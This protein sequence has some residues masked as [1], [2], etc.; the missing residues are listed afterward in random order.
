VIRRIGRGDWTPRATH[1]ILLAV[2]L[3]ALWQAA[4][5]G[6]DYTGGTVAGLDRAAGDPLY[7]WLLYG[8]TVLVL[9]GLAI[10]RGAPIILGH[11]LLGSWYLGLGRDTLASTSAFDLDVLTGITVG[12][13]GTYALLSVKSRWGYRLAGVAGMLLGQAI[14]VDGLGGDYRTG[15]GLVAAGL[16]HGILAV[17]TFVLWQ[18]QRLRRVV[19]D[20]QAPGD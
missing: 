15:T 6:L 19:D 8:S 2:Q 1:P 14:L 16:L 12:G 20:E 4:L 9:V 13:L 3:I 11:A 7:G 17:G 18:R 5:R 10:G